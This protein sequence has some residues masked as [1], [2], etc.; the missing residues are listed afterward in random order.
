MELALTFMALGDTTLEEGGRPL[1]A[2]TSS[3]LRVLDPLAGLVRAAQK[4]DR[5]ATRKLLEALGPRLLRTVRGVLGASHP[6]LDD[7]LQESLLALVRALPA[8]RGEGDVTGY[9]VRITL[10]AAIA[11]RKR[12]RA[13]APEPEPE[14]RR[15]EAL[16][17]HQPED[18]LAARRREVFRRLLD[19]LPEAQAEALAMRVVLG[20]SLEETA[21]LAGVPENTIRSRIRLAREQLKRRIEADGLWD[22]LEVES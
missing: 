20:C 21:K 12:Y 18:V 14:E 17:P 7:A 4:G 11:L 6:E 5:A 3:N 16:D 1:R 15:H 22:A 13:R 19:E 10:R 8:Y 9:A 2:E